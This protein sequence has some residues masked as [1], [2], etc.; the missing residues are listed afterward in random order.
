MSPASVTAIV[1][2]RDRL[3]KLK[4]CVEAL[5]GQTVRPHTI[6]VVD[7]DSSDGTA[8][9]LAAQP[10]PVR[11][12]RQANLGGAGGFHHGMKAALESGTDWLWLMDDD[13]VPATDALERLL[14]ADAAVG[15]GRTGFLNSLVLWTNGD[16]HSMNGPGFAPW[17]RQTREELDAGCSPITWCSFVSALVSAPAAREVGLPWADFF[18]WFDDLEYTS[19]IERAGY[20]NFLVWNSRVVHD[21]PT[22][23]TF[24]LADLNGAS[25]WKFAHGLRNQAWIVRHQ[26][27]GNAAFRCL[28]H[29]ALTC[30]TAIYHGQTRHLPFI[31]SRLMAGFRFR[32]KL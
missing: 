16:F 27:K 32:P 28:K 23:H 17:S 9:W 20:R 1:V 14:A 24:S 18:I 25:R 11:V 22:N 12:L 13:C 26:G 7:N 31:I 2:T 19:R 3:G 30:Y 21:T 8:E 5:R 15:R 10:P 6:L 29:L 4:A